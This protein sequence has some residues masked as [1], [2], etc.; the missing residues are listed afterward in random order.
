[1]IELLS[2]TKEGKMASPA[3]R[4]IGPSSL[5]I[6]DFDDTDVIMCDDS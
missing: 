2:G 4:I 1:M 6:I 3:N 5:L